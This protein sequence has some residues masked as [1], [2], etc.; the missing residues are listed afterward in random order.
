MYFWLYYFQF[1]KLKVVEAYVRR[2][3]K[4]NEHTVAVGKR[5]AARREQ[6]GLKR[7][8]LAELAE[9]ASGSLGNYERG[10]NTIPRIKLER[11]ARALGVHPTYFTDP[12]QGTGGKLLDFAEVQSEYRADDVRLP[13][14]VSDAFRRAHTALSDAQTLV[15]RL[16]R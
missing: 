14:E 13:D 9:I 7:E 3:R 15:E 4:R 5:I 1:R 2:R 11:I 10:E 16:L 6:F 12:G 8:R